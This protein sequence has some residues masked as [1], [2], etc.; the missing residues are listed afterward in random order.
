M[1]TRVRL[2]AD[3]GRIGVL[4]GK[5]RERAGRLVWEVVFPDE[6]HFVPENQFEIAD[7]ITD[8]LKLLAAGKFGRAA[9]LRQNLTYIRLSGRLANLIYSMETTNTDF[10]P[11]QFKPVINFLNSPG[12]GILIACPNDQFMIPRN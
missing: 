4:T 11:Y 5:H 9:D 1:G 3:P 7:K 8:P 6:T 12:K 10:Y 2:I